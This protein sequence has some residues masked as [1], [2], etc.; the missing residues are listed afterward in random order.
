MYIILAILLLGLMVLLHEF[1]HFIMAKIRGVKVLEFSIFF[2]TPSYTRNGKKYFPLTK[3]IK[4]TLFKLGLIPLGGYVKFKGMV[5]S[6]KP[7]V[8]NRAEIVSPDCQDED[9]FCN[10]KRWQ[11]ALI[12]LGGVIMNLITGVVLL[13]CFFLFFGTPSGSNNVNVLKGA[14]AYSAGMRS[15]D[16]ILKINDA[17][18]KDINDIYESLRVVKE[19]DSLEI[20]I[21][22]DGSEKHITLKPEMKNS[23]V[24]FGIMAGTDPLGPFGA[25]VESFKFTGFFIGSM[26]QAINM[27]FRR[28]IDVNKDLAGPVGIVMMMGDSIGYGFL[29]ILRLVALLSLMLFFFN[30]LPIPGLDGGHLLILGI[31]ALR[32]KDFSLLTKNTIN[33]M[34]MLLLLAIFFFV[35]FKDCSRIFGG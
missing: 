7:I 26:V 27:I 35:T 19:G 4:G 33:Y 17:E 6:D 3:K 20:V 18:I 22:R 25:I 24:F 9:A 8:T 1:G 12:L 29:I 31:E 2:W 13:F 11:R 30:L 14:P 28:Q 32:R 15:G 16:R 21:E 23:Q 34:G 10:K 5:K